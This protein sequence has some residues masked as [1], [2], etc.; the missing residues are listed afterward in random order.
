MF[1]DHSEFILE[2]LI[3][4]PFCFIFEENSSLFSNALIMHTSSVLRMWD[5][6]IDQDKLDAFDHTFCLH[7]RAL[8]HELVKCETGLKSVTKLF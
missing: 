1:G 6:G 2:V 4:G 3:P 5:T 8:L 7:T